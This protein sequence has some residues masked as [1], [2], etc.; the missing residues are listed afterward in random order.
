MAHDHD[1][2]M[3]AYAHALEALREDRCRRLR[4]YV[5][6]PNIKFS[7]WLVV[8]TRRLVLDYFRQRYGRSRSEDADRQHE[9]KT[10]R[11]L[12]DLV[13]DEIDPDQLVGESRTEADA[14]IRRQQ[15]KAALTRALE[16]L[17]PADRLLLALRFEDERS[18]REI[19]RT[20]ALPSVFHV[21]RRLG[22]VLSTLRR[23]LQSLGV[24]TAEP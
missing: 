17:D 19:A 15:L 5:P 18:V 11:R 14:G 3:D 16:A 22:T 9:Q 2:A 1:A 21:Y 12:E 6:E 8:V 23:T 10:R 7:S 20:L 24:D 4:A 13:A